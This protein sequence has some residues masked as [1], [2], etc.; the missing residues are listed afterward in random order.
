MLLVRMLCALS[1]FLDLGPLLP[2]KERSPHEGKRRKNANEWKR[3]GEE[4]RKGRAFPF[5]RS[6]LPDSS[7]RVE[8]ER[9][10]TRVRE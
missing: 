7:V 1:L 10:V 6:V 3:D 2:S 5:C 4:R 8:G 9:K